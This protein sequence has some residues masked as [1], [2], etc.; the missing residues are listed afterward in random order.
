MCNTSSRIRL[1]ASYKTC[2]AILWDPASR[3]QHV[4]AETLLKRVQIIRLHL[5]FL[6]RLR[7]QVVPNASSLTQKGRVRVKVKLHLYLFSRMSFYF[8]T[9]RY[10]MFLVGRLGR[11][12][13]LEN[14]SILL[15]NYPMK[16]LH[17]KLQR[18]FPPSFSGALKEGFM[19]LLGLLAT[20][21]FQ[22][23]FHKIQ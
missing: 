17:R 7:A 6:T 23:A 22:L 10:A 16:C 13:I 8:P 15:S 2:N 12:Y 18:V 9:Q 4:T 19:S 14:W 11:N 5:E 3:G 1:C 20:K 21:S